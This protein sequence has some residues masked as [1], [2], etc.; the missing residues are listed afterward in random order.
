MDEASQ[1]G[2]VGAA[3]FVN[4]VGILSQVHEPHSVAAVDHTVAFQL[5][6]AIVAAAS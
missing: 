4:E 5:H 1:Q 6:C 3:Y 2:F